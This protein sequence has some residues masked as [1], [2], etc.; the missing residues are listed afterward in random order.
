M[1][2]DARRPVVV[3]LGAWNP[4]IF[5]PEWVAFQLFDIQRGSNFQVQLLRNVTEDKNVFFIANSMVGYYVDATRCELYVRHCDQES[6]QQLAQF[7]RRV[8]D[9]LRHTPFGDFGINF[10]FIEE[11]ASVGLLDAL[12]TK[13][14]IDQHLVITI[15]EF[16]ARAQY[17]NKCQL[18]LKRVVSAGTV[19][20][21]FNYHH[22]VSEIEDLKRLD[23]DRLKNLLEASRVKIREIYNVTGDD[24]ISNQL[25]G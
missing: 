15:R 13:D 18:N 1:K 19:I 10:Q 24:E 16:I 3:L 20:F 25:P 12:S 4:A 14:D 11:N 5:N 2:L 23:F 22:T 8:I 17:D 6:F 9:T 21:D 7:V